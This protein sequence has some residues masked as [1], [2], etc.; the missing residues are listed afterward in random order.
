M[1]RLGL[2]PSA[3]RYDKNIPS[4]LFLLMLSECAVRIPPVFDPLPARFIWH[5]Q[6]YST[7][8]I[9][10]WQIVT[11]LIMYKN[12]HMFRLGLNQRSKTRSHCSLCSHSSRF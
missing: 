12:T 2:N 3:L 11:L 1:F 6:R 4:G 8:S 10:A 7:S 9:D 5:R